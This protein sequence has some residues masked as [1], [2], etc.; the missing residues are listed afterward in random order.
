VNRK[1]YGLEGK[2]KESEEGKMSINYETPF[3]MG[4]KSFA[5]GH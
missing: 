3:E 4:N 2:G 5:M 1:K